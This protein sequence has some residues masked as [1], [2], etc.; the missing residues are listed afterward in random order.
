MSKFKIIRLPED[1]PGLK[2][3]D[4]QKDQQSP[5]AVGADSDTPAKQADRKLA[6]FIMSNYKESIFVRAI[7]WLKR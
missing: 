2:A 4:V 7:S 1:T 3:E 5:G 6:E